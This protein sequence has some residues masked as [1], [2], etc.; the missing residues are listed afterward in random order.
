MV[1]LSVKG[2]DLIGDGVLRGSRSVGIVVCVIVA[3]FP[4]IVKVGPDDGNLIN[5]PFLTIACFLGVLCLVKFMQVNPFSRKS[6]V[7]KVDPSN[8]GLLMDDMSVSRGVFAS[9][10][11]RMR[12]VL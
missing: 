3:K 10:E 4:L 2:G 12:P 8:F 11:G 5:Q 7:K 1:P 6:A 9:V